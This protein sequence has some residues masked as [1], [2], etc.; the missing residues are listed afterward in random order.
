MTALRRVMCVEDDPDIGALLNRGLGAAGF[1][2]KW[3]D[4]ARGALE[5]MAGFEIG[6]A[7]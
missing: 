1:A 5:H 3:V 2:V 6:Q 7:A 4:T